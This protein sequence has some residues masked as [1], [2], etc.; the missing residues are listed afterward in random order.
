M[1]NDKNNDIIFFEIGTGNIVSY[2]KCVGLIYKI[3]FDYYGKFI[4]MAGDKGE[5]SLWKLPYE[6]SNIIVNVL[7]EIEKNKDF[8]EQFEIKYNKNKERNNYENIIMDSPIIYRT[9][10]ENKSPNEIFDNGPHKG[11]QT[12]G[13]NDINN[14]DNKL[15]NPTN[16]I[17]HN[18]Y[19][20]NQDE[21]IVKNRNNS[22]DN[23]DKKKNQIFKEKHKNYI[24][25]KI[26]NKNFMN[27]DK[28]KFNGNNNYNTD[29]IENNMKYNSLINID[30]K[31]NNENKNIPSDRLNLLKI[32]HFDNYNNILKNENSL[33]NCYEIFKK[34]RLMK[35]SLLNPNIKKNKPKDKTNVFQNNSNNFRSQKLKPSKINSWSSPKIR[36]TSKKYLE[37]N[38]NLKINNNNIFSKEQ[39][40]K[41]Q[42]IDIDIDLDLDINNIRPNYDP[43]L[44]LMEGRKNYSQSIKKL[45]QPLMN[46]NY[47]RHFSRNNDFENG[48][49]ISNNL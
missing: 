48:N 32:E 11:I 5:L 36:T 47:E 29:K 26:E 30:K 17:L 6:M 20:N 27:N 9:G 45:I 1:H 21:K 28:D 44:Y 22:K 49:Y 38:K 7:R 41:E 10:Y 2:I 42:D 33:Q 43:N 31:I 24:S 35:N 19:D 18:L 12:V 14:K 25:K 46:S 15:K 34:E 37:K 40:N 4:V 13:Y 8:W 3:S 16:K 39:F 23:K